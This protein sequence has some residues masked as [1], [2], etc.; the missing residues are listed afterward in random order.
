MEYASCLL[1]TWMVEL[2]GLQILWKPGLEFR[3]ILINWRSG[4][5]KERQ[6]CTPRMKQSTENIQDGE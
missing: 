1:S 2:Q 5:W 3:L 4:A 6:G